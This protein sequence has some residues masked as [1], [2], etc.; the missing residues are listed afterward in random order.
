MITT[1][2]ILI[3]AAAVGTAGMTVRAD[4]TAPAGEKIAALDAALERVGRLEQE[5]T[6][7]RQA[8]AAIAKSL[9]AANADSRASRDELRGLR[10]DLEALGIAVFDTGEQGSRRRLISAMAEAGR[11]RDA[12]GKLEQQLLQL[13]EAVML[14]LDRQ[15]DVEAKLRA[16]LESEL[17]ASDQ[18][19][20]AAR[21][22]AEPVRTD[23]PGLTEASVI[24]LKPDIGLA[25]LNV[26]VRSGVRLGMPFQ[27]NRQ[28]RKL[29]AAI[30]VDVRDDVCG[31]VALD[32]GLAIDQ[33]QVGD[34]ARPG[35]N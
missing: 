11:E 9:A 10:A 12:R 24:S 28:D 16:D 20:A 7:L 21:A 34:A 25:V 30:V 15:P 31:L 14:F 17:R 6:Q 4:D 29:G 33:L 35:V 23:A 1:H 5:T 27:L 18:A 2:R 32:G 8:N 22:T 3:L 13:S 26:G 19:M